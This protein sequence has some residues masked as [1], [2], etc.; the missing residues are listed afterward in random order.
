MTPILQRLAPAAF[1]SLAPFAWFYAANL[2]EPI[3]P[4]DLVLYAFASAAVA[5]VAI[6]CI[7]ALA[8]PKQ[9]RV[10]SS[11]AVGVLLFFN[12]HAICTTVLE[13]G[14]SP[15]SAAIV[16]AAIGAAAVSLAAA[17]G[18]RPGF[19]RFLVVFAA[20]NLAV[21][22]GLIAADRLSAGPLRVRAPLDHRL[23]GNDVWSGIAQR[24]PNV[25][26]I[27]VDSYPNGH[28]LRDAYGFDNSAFIDGLSDRGFTV[29]GDSYAN[30]STTLLSVPSTLEMDYIFDRDDPVYEIQRAGS[31][32][33]LPGRT[34]S[35]VNAAVGGDNRTVSFFKE[36][37][38]AY[39]H[40][41]GGLFLI[42]RCQ[43]YEDLCL[44]A[45]SAGLSDLEFRL[46][47][48]TPA[49]WLVEN[50][51]AIHSALR[52][53][54]GAPSGTGIP[55]LQ[56][57]IDA[58]PLP[59]PF[60]LYAH[61]ASP[62]RPYTNDALCNLLPLEFERSGN[63][64]FLAQLQCVSLQLE[65]LLDSIVRRD[66]EAIVV[67]SADHGARLSVRK[68]TSLYEHSERQVR[69]S[70]AILQAFRGPAK[71]RA[72]LRQDLTPIN[73]MRWVFACLGDEVPRWLPARHF[74]ARSDAPE[75]GRIRQVE[76][77]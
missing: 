13:N 70:L 20:A 6:L 52:P 15:G 27:V 72:S 33:R 9:G 4:G 22:L 44:E 43:G 10:A 23:A 61:I 12:Y 65:E 8:G 17:L 31:W 25:Y 47:A 68:G 11:V 76:L 32:R 57:R 74:I 34:R 48:L 37:G 46:L 7:E 40:Y 39:V 30:F 41:E 62:H 71:C 55:E 21:P 2:H 36:L 26:W 3:R 14:G 49:L 45:G 42:T 51:N 64:H 38:Y 66:P 75:R 67:L 29:T 58:P 1:F 73:A 24:K 60:F 69:E 35:G 50:S 63:R 77:D 16:Y 5:V 18:A 28:V 19:Q 56:A 59:E 54:G 53:P